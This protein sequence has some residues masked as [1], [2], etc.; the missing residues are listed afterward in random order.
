MPCRLPLRMGNRIDHLHRLVNHQRNHH[1]EPVR[2]ITNEKQQTFIPQFKRWNQDNLILKNLLCPHIL[3]TKKQQWRTERWNRNRTFIPDEWWTRWTKI[4]ELWKYDKDSVPRSCSPSCIRIPMGRLKNQVGV[5]YAKIIQC[6]INFLRKGN[7]RTLTIIITV[8][9][10]KSVQLQLTLSPRF[11]K[12]C[13]FSNI[14]L[15]IC[16][17]VIIVS[18]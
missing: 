16:C 11:K 12:T 8:Y 10:Y 13:T 14:V 17:G 2:L 3:Y 7:N 1:L 6:E 4:V 9:I 5:H 15:V 18:F